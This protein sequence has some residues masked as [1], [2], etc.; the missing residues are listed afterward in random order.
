MP[1]GTP[2]GSSPTRLSRNERGV[3][4]EVRAVSGCLPS[5]ETHPDSLATVHESL[6]ESE[7]RFRLLVESVRE[8]AIFMLDPTGVVQTWNAGAERIKGYRA[9][10]IIGQHFSK[11]YRPQDLWKTTHELEVATRDGRVEDDGWRVRKDGSLFWA[12]V[13]ITCVRDPSG[14]VVGFAKVTRDMSERQRAEEALRQSEERFRLLVESVRDYAIFMLDPGGK[15]ATWN[16]G[17]ERIKGYRADEIIGQHFSIFYPEEDVGAGKCEMELERRRAGRALR[18]RGMARPQGRH[19][20]LGERRHHAA[21]Q[22]SGRPH[23]LREG[24]PRHDRTATRRGRA[25]AVG[26][27]RARTRSHAGG[28]LRNARRGPLRRGCRPCGDRCRE[29]A[30]A[31]RHVH[32]VLAERAQGARP[33]RTARLQPGAGRA[34]PCDHAPSREIRSTPSV[35][36]RP[37]RSGSRRRRSTSRSSP[38]SRERASRDRGVRAFWCVPLVA[39]GRAIGMIGVGYHA[40][41]QFSQDER[42]FVGTFAR[43]S[44]QALARARRVEA[45][46]AA[47]TL[48]EQLRASL[49]TTLRSIGDA[50]IATDARRPRHADERRRRVPHGLAGAGSMRKAPVRRLSHRE[51]ADPRDGTQSRVEGARDGRDRG[52]GEPHGSRRAGRPRDSDRRQR[53]PDPGRRRRHR[54][55]RAGLSRRQREKARRITTSAP[56]RCDRRA[57]RV[58]RLRAHRRTGR[59]AGR[60]G[61]CRLVRGGPGR[62]GG[63]VAK[64]SRRRSRRPDEGRA[65]EGARCEVPAETGRSDGRSQRPADRPRGALRA[66][67]GRAAPCQLRR[68]RASAHRARA[69]PSLC[70]G[71][72]AGSTRSRAR[73]DELRLRRVRTELHGGGS[74]VRRGARAALRE[75]DRE[76]SSL[77]VGAASA[78]NADVAN[79]AKDEFLAVVSHELRTPLNAIMGWAKM[80]TA[81]EFDERRRQGAV[82]T[83]ERN[84]IAMAQLIEDLLDMS[85]VISGKM[86]LEVQHVDLPSVIEAAI[87]SVRPAAAAKGIN[88]VAVL[89]RTPSAV[90]GDPTRLQ[91]VVWNLLSNA[92]KFTP[93]GGR[94][95]VLLRRAASSLEIVVADTG[96]GIAPRFCRMSSIHSGRKT[97]ARRARAAGSASASPSRGSSSNCTAARSPAHSE[98]EGRGATFTVSLPISAVAPSCEPRERAAR[99]FV[100]DGSF[101]RPAHASRPPRPRRRRR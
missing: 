51:R 98:G 73:R 91:Q 1:A 21:P 57:G 47:G 97:R 83:I 35:P 49:S 84:A 41:R 90:I 31:S 24:H 11:F 72:P 15:V 92:V 71:G 8:Y 64:T 95:D 14:E 13:V 85:R 99:Q 88:L 67:P 60:S 44:A 26:T 53:R 30:R 32:S 61:P 59:T 65:R 58:A 50:V 16:V 4:Q 7:A 56:R 45:E 33:R 43:Q 39:E 6:L 17:A 70:D 66:D 79:R 89:D 34:H 12:N 3:G 68:R 87:D 82:E 81:R 78:A 18:G 93:K 86:R 20:F 9:G 2:R 75:R 55:R 74:P 69:S 37:T 100:A 77:C 96:K 48:A 63:A 28:P 46:R 29:E 54:R 19:S 76:R 38:R 22:R 36:A 52:S 80:L 23:R 42:E 40:E 10:E 94:V 27:G 101:E 62:R 25:A 5:G